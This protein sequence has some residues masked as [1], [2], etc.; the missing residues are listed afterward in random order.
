VKEAE[1]KQQDDKS[2]KVELSESLKQSNK[3]S[4]II[5]PIANQP[6]ELY[7]LALKANEAIYDTSTKNV[8]SRD[9]T[10][11]SILLYWYSVNTECAL[12]LS[13]FDS[14]IANSYLAKIIATNSSYPG[15]YMTV[16]DIIGKARY[17]RL[18]NMSIRAR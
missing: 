15:F 16:R 3:I 8:N 11:E 18:R 17:D 5:R 9:N 12:L 7:L 14:G 10:Y 13:K 6:K 2:K 1:L 4:N